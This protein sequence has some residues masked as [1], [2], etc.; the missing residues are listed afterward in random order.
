MLNT[1][2]H[3][4]PQ[5][6]IEDVHILDDQYGNRQQVH[7][8]RRRFTYAQI[9]KGICQDYELGYVDALATIERLEISGLLGNTPDHFC[10]IICAGLNALAEGARS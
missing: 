4:D 3:R 1:A 10:R 2:F 9:R 6:E 5:A 7:E 8:F